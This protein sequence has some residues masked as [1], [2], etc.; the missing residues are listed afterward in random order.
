[1]G[2]AKHII[3]FDEQVDTNEW[4]LEELVQASE[5]EPLLQEKGFGPVHAAKCLTVWSY[6]CDVRNQ[7]AF[8]SRRC[9]PRY[10]FVW[11]YRQAPTQSRRR[12]ISQCRVAY[13]H[14][15]KDGPRSRNTPIRGK[16][17]SET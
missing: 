7:A 1:V 13:G 2:L 10:C 4:Q 12:A 5:A 15:L 14:N 17:S 6:R 9:Q 3:D 11:Q 16:T 8:A